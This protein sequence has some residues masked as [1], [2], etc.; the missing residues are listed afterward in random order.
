MNTVCRATKSRTKPSTTLTCTQTCTPPHTKHTP[1]HA[2]H[3]PTHSKF[4]GPAHLAVHNLHIHRCAREFS[5]A[6]VGWQR[7]HHRATP[8]DAPLKPTHILTIPRS[9][10]RGWD[11]ELCRSAR[12]S[13]TWLLVCL[14]LMRLAV[15]LFGT[16]TDAAA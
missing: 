10:L 11:G 16:H 13:C 6:A 2:K 15:G 12:R 14:V 7:A 9:T 1:T 3:A 8:Y 5:Q 4:Y